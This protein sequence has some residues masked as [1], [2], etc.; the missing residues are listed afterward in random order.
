M[1]LARMSPEE[2]LAYLK[3]KV[4][5][6]EESEIL[7]TVHRESIRHWLREKAEGAKVIMEAEA[8]PGATFDFKVEWVEGWRERLMGDPEARMF[9][10]TR[11]RRGMVVKVYPDGRHVMGRVG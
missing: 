9:I 7:W 2:L 8:A 5:R 6:E 10:V 11:G 4:E 1:N 3:A